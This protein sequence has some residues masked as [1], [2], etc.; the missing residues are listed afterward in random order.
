MKNH[1]LLVINKR[2]VTI[3]ML[4]FQFLTG[5]K[6]PGGLLQ[7]S[8]ILSPDYILAFS[9]CYFLGSVLFSVLWTKTFGRGPLEM[10]MRK[11]SG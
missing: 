11:I 10:L 4:I 8:K 3:G 9:F 6:Y 7:M 2:I 5:S 1:Y